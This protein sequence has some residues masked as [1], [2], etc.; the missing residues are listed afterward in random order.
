MTVR[1]MK[2]IFLLL[3]L[4]LVAGCNNP[5]STQKTAKPPTPA[6][7]ISP[8]FYG[9]D[10]STTSTLNSYKVQSGHIKI[11]KSY[12]LDGADYNRN[13]KLTTD[14]LYTTTDHSISATRL[15]DGKVIWNEP[16][17][18]KPASDPVV[19]KDTVYIAVL[20][21][22]SSAIS[23]DQPLVMYAFNIQ[24]GSLRWRQNLPLQTTDELGIVQN[25]TSIQSTEVSNNIL[26]MGTS[27]GAAAFDL[28]SH[29]LVWYHHE[30]AAYNFDKLNLASDA[31]YLQAALGD[32]TLYV[33]DPQTGKTIWSY[34]TL[35]TNKED[36]SNPFSI[37]LTPD[38]N[39]YEYNNQVVREVDRLTGKAGWE[40][41]YRQL[42]DSND[43]SKMLVGDQ[44][45]YFKTGPGGG[46]ILALNTKDGSKLWTN[47]STD[48]YQSLAIGQGHIYALGPQTLYAY[49]SHTG[50]LLWKQTVDASNMEINTTKNN[51]YMTDANSLITSSIANNVT[52]FD[53]AAGKILWSTQNSQIIKSTFP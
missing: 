44:G 23:D 5:A 37:V 52:S 33:L 46:D 48:S 4:L 30:Y 13:I 10:A 42:T 22:Q 32:H 31:L 49:N 51:L 12:P 40:I 53:P 45:I 8:V 19:T 17:N 39:I 36:F 24:D 34:D 25:D 6:K 41:Q 29:K 15:S 21:G 7:D 50:A 2:A 20:G 3:A 14:I 47:Q 16:L 9:F 35:T 26:Y 1:H 38:F 18:N 43:I 11:Q 27:Y 28:T